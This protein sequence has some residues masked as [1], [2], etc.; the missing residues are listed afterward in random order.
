MWGNG[1]S[2]TETALSILG[3]FDDDDDD[4]DDDAD[5]FEDEVFCS[6]FDAVISRARTCLIV[7][8]GGEDFLR[9][10]V[11]DEDDLDDDDDDGVDF[12]VDAVDALSGTGS[13]NLPLVRDDDD[14]APCLLDDGDL[15]DEGGN[16]FDDCL[17]VFVMMIDSNG[18]M[19]FCK[20]MIL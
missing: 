15:Y 8:L 19:L 10:V 6:L 17:D 18:W 5:F 13:R 3:L 16:T 14:F 7:L 9:F 20:R 1:T 11:V 4:D 12:D 2:K